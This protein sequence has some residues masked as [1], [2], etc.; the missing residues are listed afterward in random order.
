MRARKSDKTYFSFN[1][2]FRYPSVTFR[3]NSS[4]SHLIIEVPV[5]QL[6]K[7][8]HAGETVSVERETQHF[9]GLLNSCMKCKITFFAE[10]TTMHGP[11]RI[12]QGKRLAFLDLRKN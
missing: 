4:L 10:T 3:P 11:K 6:K 9:C 12:F 2:N 8:K 7:F 1:K 5:A